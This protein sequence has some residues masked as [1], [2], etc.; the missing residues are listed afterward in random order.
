MAHGTVMAHSVGAKPTKGWFTYDAMGCMLLQECKEDI[1]RVSKISE[2]QKIFPNYDWDFV[3]QEFEEMV[4]A[5]DKVGN[6]TCIL[7]LLNTS[8]GDIVVFITRLAII[9]I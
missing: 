1:K 2:I 8:H 9:S 6:H 3:G 7:H 4:E 5:L